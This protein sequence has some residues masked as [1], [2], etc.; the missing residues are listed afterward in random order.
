[1]EIDNSSFKHVLAQANCHIRRNTEDLVLHHKIPGMYDIAF[2]DP[3]PV[4][5]PEPQQGIGGIFFPGFYLNGV[6]LVFELAVVGDDKIDLNIV[7]VFFF[8]VMGVKIKLMSVGCQHLR[9][10]IFVEHT[11]I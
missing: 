2:A 8:A 9:N 3:L 6:H 5:F 10:C 1:M 4:F 7:A 11:V